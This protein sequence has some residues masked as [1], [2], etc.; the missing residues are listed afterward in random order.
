MEGRR[1]SGRGKGGRVKRRR[2]SMCGRGSGCKS[3]GRG[4]RVEGMD[5]EWRR[6]DGGSGCGR[7]RRGRGRSG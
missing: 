6:V 2:R 5:D 1:V 3:D 7:S 4:W